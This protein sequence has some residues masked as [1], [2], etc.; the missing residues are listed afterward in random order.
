M[1]PALRGLWSIPSGSVL[2]FAHRGTLEPFGQLVPAMRGARGCGQGVTVLPPGVCQPLCLAQQLLISLRLGG[3]C[4]HHLCLQY[5]NLLR[6]QALHASPGMVSV[7]DGD[8]V[9]VCT[10]AFRLGYL[11]TIE[12]MHSHWLPQIGSWSGT[13][14]LQSYLSRDKYVHPVLDSKRSPIAVWQREGL[15]IVL[16]WRLL[17]RVRNF[18]GFSCYRVRALH[19]LCL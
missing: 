3:C 8:H 9:G 7:A 16:Q 14:S 2:R 10:R 5:E 6:R 11:P 12:P 19:G 13:P 15:L 1:S 4:S 17:R 18:R